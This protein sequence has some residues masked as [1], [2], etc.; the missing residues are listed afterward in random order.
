MVKK[1]IAKYL[2]ECGIKQTFISRATGMTQQSVS[3]ML[4]GDR[5][6]EIEEYVKICDALHLPYDFFMKSDKTAS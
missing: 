1:R 3:T 5:N 2:E 6:L 4:R